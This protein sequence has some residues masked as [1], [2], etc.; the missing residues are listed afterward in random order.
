MALILDKSHITITSVDESGNTLTTGYTNLNYTDQFGSVWDNPYM[1]VDNIN[2][3]KLN[4]KAKIYISVYKDKN[5][6]TNKNMALSEIVHEVVSPSVYEIYFKIV[7]DIN[8]FSKAYVYIQEMI[9]PS[10]KSDE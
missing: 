3:D 6:R 1:V 4:K 9:Y 8:F 2:L 5:S 7:D 10:W